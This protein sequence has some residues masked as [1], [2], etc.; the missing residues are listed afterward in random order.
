LG[1]IQSRISD[2]ESTNMPII[3]FWD[4]GRILA[5]KPMERRGS[6]LGSVSFFNNSIKCM[7]DRVQSCRIFEFWD[8][9]RIRE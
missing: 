7:I 8:F 9:G 4:F 3:E 5:I 6:K 1:L 2:R